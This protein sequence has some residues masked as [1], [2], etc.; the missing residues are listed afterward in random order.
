MKSKIYI[1]FILLGIFSL[2]KVAYACVKK[3]ALHHVVFDLN[4]TPQTTN[5]CCADHKTSHEKEKSC[6]N[7][8]TMIFCHSFSSYMYNANTFQLYRPFTIDGVS[9]IFSSEEAFISSYF[10]TFWQPPKIG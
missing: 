4:K 1:L 9:R 8:C 7:K 5:D 6:D 3:T 10:L 2:P